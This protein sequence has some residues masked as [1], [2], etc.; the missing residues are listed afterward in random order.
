MSAYVSASHV[1]LL[2]HTIDDSRSDISYDSEE[3]EQRL[4][5]QEW[6]EAKVESYPFRTVPD[7]GAWQ[8]LL[9][10]L[11]YS[12]DVFDPSYLYFQAVNIVAVN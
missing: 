7:F 11:I 12:S 5:Q 2:A 1:S 3:E 9:G 8:A 6:D 10:T 4:A